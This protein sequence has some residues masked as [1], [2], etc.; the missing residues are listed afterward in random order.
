M[1]KNSFSKVHGYIVRIM[2][3]L[4]RSAE[5]HFKQPY[6]TVTYGQHYGGHVFSWDNHHMSLRF[7]AGGEP[8]QMRFFLENMLS[9]QGSNGFV[10]CVINAAD[11]ISI[12]NPGFHAQPFLAQNAAIYI[13]H[14]GDTA[15]AAKVYGPLQRY[16]LYWQAQSAAPFGLF[17]WRETWMSGFDNEIA[18][19]IFP[20]D[21]IIPPDLNAWLYLELRSMAFL[22]EIMRNEIDRQNYL[23]QA[24]QLKKA[25][26]SY[27]WDEQYGAY[28]AYDLSAGKT[29][30]GWGDGT[31]SSD[32]GQYAYLSCPALV[33]L[34]ARIAGQKQA[35]QMIN[36]YVLD[37][38]HFRS[39]YGIRSLAKSS[40]YYNNARW[41]NPPRFGDHRRLTNS[42]WQGPV[43][44]PLN[45]FVFHALLHYGFPAEAEKLADDTFKVI[46]LSLDKFGFMRE[47]FHGET[48]EPLYADYFASWNILADLMPDYLPG[49]KAVISSLLF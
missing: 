17:R 2:P 12:V 27:L 24:E 34:F 5:G 13:K 48:G 8:E 42:N 43:W 19:T 4:K 38:E 37:P 36:K 14:T 30:I 7:A 22:A 11:G 41:G 10:P 16:L 28:A 40:E 35:E 26:N 20:P 23:V 39:P 3:L 9:F 25:I 18:G 46:A 6:L 31:L 29:R 32:V 21:T 49:G 44:I 45:W 33:P 1:N 47:N 15:W